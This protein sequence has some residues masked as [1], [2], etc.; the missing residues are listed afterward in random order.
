MADQ[1][2][3]PPVPRLPID[4]EIKRETPQIGTAKESLND[5]N[6]AAK[7]SPERLGNFRPNTSAMND[8]ETQVR[9]LLKSRPPVRSRSPLDV[10]KDAAP[11]AASLVRP[12]MIS[13]RLAT[14]MGGPR[15]DPAALV[16]DAYRL[17]QDGDGQTPSVQQ[18]LVTAQTV[19]KVGSDQAEVL[20]NF[21]RFQRTAMTKSLALQ[22]QQTI[23]AKDQLALVASIGEMLEKKLDAIKLNTA[24]PEMAKS[25]LFRQ[26]KDATVKKLIDRTTKEISDRVYTT[27]KPLVQ[28]H[29]LDPLK[30]KTSAYLAGD[31]DGAKAIRTVSAK[32]RAAGARG[33]NRVGETVENLADRAGRRVDQ[34]V[35]WYDR[36]DTKEKRAALA[37][38]ASELKRSMSARYEDARRK[39]G[40]VGDEVR[41]GVR[42][43]R[44]ALSTNAPVLDRLRRKVSGVDRTKLLRDP[45]LAGER[46]VDALAADE[47][48][49][50]AA[51]TEQSTNSFTVARSM[52]QRAAEAKLGR[53][54]N[55]RRPEITR[56]VEA[57]RPSET[58]AQGLAVEGQEA[59]TP[60]RSRMET[61]SARAGELRERAQTGLVDLINASQSGSSDLREQ[62]RRTVFAARPTDDAEDTP[63]GAEAPTTT[64]M[65]ELLAAVKTLPRTLAEKLGALTAGTMGDSSRPVRFADD[66]RA[67]LERTPTAVEAL[68]Q[69]FDAWIEAKTITDAKTLELLQG[70]LERSGSG[71]GGG[72]SAGDAS[73]PKRG[74]FKRA[75]L[76][77]VKAPGAALNFGLRMGARASFGAAKLYGKAT[78]GTARFAGRTMVGAGRMLF[79]GGAERS[80]LVDI[81]RKDQLGS[82]QPLVTQDQLEQGLV[83]QDGTRIT[84]VQDI[85]QPVFDPRT[86]Q[87]VISDDDLD[88]GLVDSHGDYLATR[89]RK[90]SVAGAL[91]GVGK[92]AV[93][94]AGRVGMKT[95]PKAFGV[96]GQMGRGMLNL[97]GGGLKGAGYLAGGL[98]KSGIPTLLTRAALGGAGG[99]AGM[100]RDLFGLGLKA[101][102]GVLK[103]GGRLAGNALGLNKKGKGQGGLTREDLEDVVAKRLDDIHDLLLEHFSQ[104]KVS[105][106][107]DGDGIRN[108]SYA[109]YLRRQ[110][111]KRDA[112]NAKRDSDTTAAAKRGGGI[113]AGL[114]AL[115]GLLKGKKPGEEA[116]ESGGGI[117][118]AV[119]DVATTAAGG[120][121]ATKAAGLKKAASGLKKVAGGKAGKLAAL[122]ALTAGGLYALTPGTANA[123][124]VNPKDDE[125]PKSDTPEAPKWEDRPDMLGSIAASAA[126]GA[127]MWAAGKAGEKYGPAV[128]E[129]LAEKKAAQAAASTAV[130]TAAKTASVTAGEQALKL[131]SK[132]ALELGA[133]QA[134][135][136]GAKKVPFLGVVAGAGFGFNR[137]LDGDFTGA[138]AEVASGVVSIIPGF[139]TGAS[140]A[141]DAWLGY[142]DYDL[143][144][145]NPHIL[146]IKAR[147]AAYGID[148]TAMF[149]Y[150]LALEKKQHKAIYDANGRMGPDDFANVAAAFGMDTKDT[151]ATEFFASWYTNRF[152]RAFLVYL[153]CLAR[154]GK[155]YDTAGTM[156]AEQA[157]ELAKEFNKHVAP[158]VTKYDK[159][160]PTMEVFNK[161]MGKEPPKVHDKPTEAAVPNT[162]DP[163]K[164]AKSAD[165]GGEAAP[166]G[167]GG[168]GVPSPVELGPQI[169]PAMAGAADQIRNATPNGQGGGAPPTVP[170]GGPGGQNLSAVPA[171]ANANS[172]NDNK[173]VKVAPGGIASASAD[174]LGELS[175]RY[176][177]GKRGSAAIGYDSTGGTSY[178][179]Y[180]IA[181][182][183]GTFARFV[184]WLKSRGGTAQQVADMLQKA[185]PYD[186]GS[187]QGAVP[188]AWLNAVK[189]GMMGDLEHEFIKASHYEPAFKGLS[190]DAQ[191]M[192]NSSKALQ[193]VL[194]STAVQHGPGGAKG[195]FNNTFKPNQDPAT[196]IQRIYQV[197]STK[198]G[199]SKPEVRASV[200][201]RF[202]DESKRAIAMLANDGKPAAAP[203]PTAQA[204]AAGGS[205]PA[206]AGATPPAPGAG[207]GGAPDAAAGQAAGTT[208]AGGGAP[209]AAPSAGGDAGS[210]GGGAAAPA[211]AGSTP[212]APPAPQMAA[213]AAA[214]GGG[215]ASGAGT[216]A[217]APVAPQAQGSSNAGMPA[218][219]SEPIKSSGDPKIDQYWAS[220]GRNIIP[221]SGQNTNP[222]IG[223]TPQ[224]PAAAAPQP[225]QKPGEAQIGGMSAGDFIKAMSDVQAQTTKQL[226][227]GFGKA[228]EGNLG[229]GSALFGAL[230]KTGSPSVVNVQA[231]NGNGGAA[232]GAARGLDIDISKK[233]TDRY[234]M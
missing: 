109:D 5:E 131:S 134:L 85:N 25:S 167:G 88:A 159:V 209:A 199:S 179:K 92:S 192:V 111:E 127:A 186:T 24:A 74:F 222:S 210:A 185:G 113:T 84:R 77:L 135:K 161:V 129:K 124:E 52:L 89:K 205:A 140:L 18:T 139:G 166:G 97:A 137:L 115:L 11:Q 156:T 136:S 87:V 72:G 101:A 28:Q 80:P 212:S 61:L 102:G 23:V 51:G 207:G 213:V 138:G 59:R 10:V 41:R 188:D 223:T 70:I 65:G 149:D 130:E 230:S 220:M 195:I 153:E 163:T 231:V 22:Y 26:V 180:Q 96:Y 217:P 94:T 14:T 38:K 68:K 118:G 1:P 173:P 227:E 86:G 50:S 66:D 8:A 194:W 160:K 78:L 158:L 148:D 234:A 221:N 49:E 29:V 46:Q 226:L 172:S 106:D 198:F 6:V 13:P 132:E 151:K 206:P 183:T 204:G 95:L 197:R 125:P 37:A 219:W 90:M 4:N 143:A 19:A 55:L 202:A 62:I 162:Y 189:S 36:E 114:G 145:N 225:G 154:M 16:A 157:E 54:V 2:I 39:A 64:P 33:L 45:R 168:P 196:Y 120:W 79:G 53:R 20:Q 100:Y 146:L 123:D 155:T 104:A 200:M 177:S 83:L 34:G 141:I 169:A 133:K 71:G 30:R 214:T 175:A 184:A 63:P 126:P 43:S 73:G 32:V 165:G 9:T 99:L 12:S 112:R 67:L 82:G 35:Q 170:N 44:A 181:A 69:S 218:W 122:G 121:L 48:A 150:V 147:M 105:G 47:T 216:N 91:Y 164:A 108:G 27:A 116:D 228:L 81:Y 176:E 128:M 31:S 232:G 187:R 142:H 3:L 174:G 21:Y 144:M 119:G 98:L 75:A 178:G 233:R 103:F 57:K 191:K 215:G 201:N 229:D 110:K 7:P 224:T 190:A 211:A 117:G 17:G 15:R 58:E 107:T 93:G 171:P 42:D 193:D 182:K 152:T 208:P 40:F 56:L 76:G 60:W 203:A